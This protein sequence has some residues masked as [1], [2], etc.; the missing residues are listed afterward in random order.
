MDMSL[1]EDAQ[2]T[3]ATL[4]PD[5]FFFMSPYRSFTTS[6]CFARYTEPAVSG[7]SPDSPFQQKLRQQ[8]AAAKSQGIVNPILVGAIP[9]DTCQ[10]SS[11]FIPLEWQLFSRQEKQRTARYFTDHQSLTVTARKAIPEQDAFEAMVARAAMLTATPDVDKVVLSRLIDITTNV[12]VDSGAL[13]ERLVAQNPVSYN[14]HVPLA[15]G[16]VLLGAS[17]ELL[18]RKEGE[19]FSSLPLAG[20]ARRQ[21]DDVLDREAGNRLLASQKDRHEHEL[22]TQAMKQILRDRSTEL[23]LPSSPQLITTPTLW[24]LGTP[25][26]GKANAGENALTL[27]CLLHPTPALSGFPHQVAKKLIAELEPFDR[28]LFGGIVGWCDAEGN[29]EWVV[30]IR[31]AK[32]RG[33]QVRLF[34]GA[35]IVPASSPVGEWRETGVKLSTMLNVFGLH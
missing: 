10:P 34:A 17:P 2:E 8:F 12:A 13:L 30:T 31:C 14:F 33:N 24:H 18:L 3:M 1:A 15:D 4:A 11:L 21:P 9:F 5:R 32:L 25:F 27:A 35:G 7:D 23:Q 29:G 6:G 22:V 26:E 16:G 20:S 28:E 19:R